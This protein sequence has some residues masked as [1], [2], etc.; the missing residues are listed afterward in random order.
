M[1]DGG[2]SGSLIV[3]SALTVLAGT[4]GSEPP[5]GEGWVPLFNGNDLTGWKVPSGNDGI[6]KV[7]DGVIDCTPRSDL[8]GDNSLW[9]KK[10]LGDFTL[11]IEWRLKETKGEYPMPNVL[12]DGSNETDEN[13][14]IV[15]TTRPNAD[16]GIY[17]RGSSKSQI[18]IWCW[19]VGSGEVWGYRNDANMP[20]EVRAGATPNVC[21]DKPVGEWN[22]FVITMKGERLTVV[23]NGKTVIDNVPLP[24]V[25]ESGTIALQHHGGYNAE[26]ATWSPA[27]SLIQF[28]NI[29]YKDLAPQEGS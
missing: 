17:L 14:N 21:A 3:L 1:K 9:S 24:G 13:G 19:P 29:Y 6:W 15:T 23:L 7:V 28:R 18:N 10:A 27:S 26:R 5:S 20:P 11:H 22:T 16:S 12:P 4:A 8:K 2:L 25:P